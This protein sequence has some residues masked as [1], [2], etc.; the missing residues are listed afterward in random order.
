MKTIL[1]FL[2]FL[3]NINLIH[4]CYSQESELKE[5][6]RYFSGS[7]I[8][9]TDGM[10]SPIFSHF[11]MDY[12]TLRILVVFCKFPDCIWNPF[13]YGAGGATEFWHT[14][15]T[16]IYKP[17][18]ADS[19]VCP[20]TT[21][22]W[23]NSITAYFRDISF[24]KFFVIGDVYNDLYTFQH[25]VNYYSLDSGRNIGYA[26]KELLETIDPYVDYS[27][28]D[29]FAP[30]D[31]YNK[32]HPD[33]V[34]D[35]VLLVFRFTHTAKIDGSSYSG[36]CGLGG[37]TNSF[38]GSPYLV[39][40]GKQ[41]KASIP[42]DTIRGSGAI[43]SCLTP[44]EFWISTHE[45]LHYQ[46]GLNHS[47]G[48]G[49][50]D[51]NAGLVS[52]ED[53]V[54]FNWGPS[55]INI[56][57]YNNTITLRDFFTTGDFARIDHGGSY[58]YLENRRR[59]NYI[60]SVRMK[61][62]HYF[63]EQEVRP[64]SRDSMLVIYKKDNNYF[65]K[66]NL[67]AA[68]G[69]WNW[70]KLNSHYVVDSLKTHNIFF[71]ESLNRNNG[72]TIIDLF[73]RSAVKINGI[74]YY[75]LKDHWGCATDSNSFFDIGYNEV[76]S[77]WSNPSLPAF[78]NDSLTIQLLERNT[79]G[80]LLVKF[81][82]TNQLQAPPS[83]PQFLKIIE[84]YPIDSMVCHPKLVWE[85][86]IEPDMLINNNDK[87]YRIYRAL[88]SDTSLTPTNF[89]EFATVYIHKDSIPS[90]IDYSINLYD[91]TEYDRP[92]Y[93]IPFPIRYK[94]KAIDINQD[95]SVYSDYTHCIG[96]NSDSGIDDDGDSDNF[97]ID[98][99]PKIYSLKQNYPNPFNPMTNISYDLPRN[100]FVKILIFDITGRLI[101]ILV[102]EYK[103]AGTYIVSLNAS[104]LSSGIYF[105]R[106]ESNGFTE[107]KRM[108][109]LK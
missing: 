10:T 76:L 29:K 67:F 14:E 100:S 92:P 58:Y 21:N 86:N 18:W 49:T 97:S 2:A 70:Q 62:W 17:N 59:L 4:N 34:V 108:L 6:S 61:D 93:G 47:S 85:H 73:Q 89:I 33:G 27:Q 88:E 50:C 8:G 104:D 72:E 103:N 15:N 53:R 54:Y 16:T 28:Y 56:P 99:N 52:A 26:T 46:Y 22:I 66:Y 90:F 107:S 91:C 42:D 37:I 44:W 1:V 102:N 84:Y 43:A 12:D 25:N 69:R 101:R 63:P 74:P 31:T 96:V 35:F 106:M 5:L 24:G 20:N 105:Y 65:R 55:T 82:Y 39:L 109:F 68:D 23:Q 40:D 81:I 48:L 45:F 79:E 78:D 13:V 38:A 94:I 30:L 41:I 3:I 64:H 80:S 98:G 19:I 95:S 32:R 11:P 36:I 77:P 83:K 71:R 75:K 60:A 87:K 57:Q 51:M 7:V 9:G